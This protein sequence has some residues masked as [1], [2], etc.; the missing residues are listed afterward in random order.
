MIRKIFM[1]QSII[2]K[3]NSIQNVIPEII[4]AKMIKL[5]IIKI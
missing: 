5:K 3:I 2:K 4:I 1:N